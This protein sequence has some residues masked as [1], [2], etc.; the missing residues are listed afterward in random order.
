MSAAPPRQHVRTP[1][2]RCRCEVFVRGWYRDERVRFMQKSDHSCALQ[3][4]LLIALIRKKTTIHPQHRTR[5]KAS[6]VADEKRDCF[7]D[8][9][10][11]SSAPQRCEA[12]IFAAASHL[13][14]VR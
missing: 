1:S 13:F 2:Q 12:E 8:I 3:P 7:T 5:N 11:R 6:F 4:H 9:I 14:Q 10:G